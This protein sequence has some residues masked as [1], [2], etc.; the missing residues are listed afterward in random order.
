MSTHFSFLFSLNYCWVV[1]HVVKS[2]SNLLWILAHNEILGRLGR[3]KIPT[4][5]IEKFPYHRWI[6]VPTKSMVEFKLYEVNFIKFRA[7][8]NFLQ[9]CNSSHRNCCLSSIFFRINLNNHLWTLVDRTTPS[10][11]F[12]LSIRFENFGLLNFETGFSALHSSAPKF[13]YQK[14]N[15][16]FKF[17]I[18]FPLSA[19]Q[20]LHFGVK[21]L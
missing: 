20:L 19:F 8:I 12:H 13:G 14:S 7:Y 6:R 9:P 16:L 17:S 11:L 1:L 10:T 4:L 2:I 15:F 5:Y 3:V 18:V 21:N